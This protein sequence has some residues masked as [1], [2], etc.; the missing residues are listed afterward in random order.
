MSPFIT[1]EFSF[2]PENTFMLDNGI[3]TFK[4]GTKK[5]V[6]M[7]E[8]VDIVNTKSHKVTQLGDIQ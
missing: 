5:I 1:H 8:P 6:F 2:D 7:P 4:K 3:L